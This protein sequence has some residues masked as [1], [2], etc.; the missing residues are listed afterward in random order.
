M[1]LKNLWVFD[2]YFGDSLLLAIA[3][4]ILLSPVCLAQ[5]YQE[6]LSAFNGADF[7]QALSLGQDYVRQNPKHAEARYYLAKTLL[8]GGQ[9][10]LAEEQLRAAMAL[11]P[12]EEVMANCVSALKEIAQKNALSGSANSLP[13]AV[14]PAASNSGNASSG[15]IN[16]GASTEGYSSRAANTSNYSRG[17]AGSASL[18]T[19]SA[20]EQ[21]PQS[22][23]SRASGI[24]TYMITKPK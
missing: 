23:S 7:K 20:Q 2:R 10:A 11:G 9:P 22:K 13:G 21:S 5:D 8:K 14:T 1:D 12:N 4:L 24:K 17:T 19:K 18:Q 6:F 15:G 16:S 3:S